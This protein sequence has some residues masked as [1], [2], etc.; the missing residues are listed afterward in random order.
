MRLDGRK[1]AISFRSAPS[2][3]QTLERLGY[4]Q[5]LRRSLG[6]FSSF[7]LSF[8]VI[9]MTSGLFADY[10]DGLRAGGPAFVWSWLIV[11]AGQ[12]LVAMVFAQLSRQIPLSGYAYQWAR[13]LAGDRL[14]FWAGWIMIVQF[15]TGM[16][17]VAYALASYLVPFFGLPNSNGNVVLA[18]VGTLVVAALINHYGIR[19][20]SMVNDVSVIAEILGSVLIGLA[21][22]GIALV[23][24]THPLSFLFTY[25]HQSSLGGY[26]QAFLA[27]SL[28]SVWTLGG[29]EAA[30]NVAEETHL[31]EKRIPIAILLSEVLAVVFGLL[32]L[33]GFTLAVPSVEVAS[34]DP[35]PLLYIIGS[36]FPKYVV[37][38]ALLCVSVA[39]FACVLA[40]LTT[41]TR[42]IWAMARDGKLPASRFLAKVSEH[43]V[44]VNAI[45]VVIPI[46]AVFTFW[47]QVEV[48]ILALCTF[49][50][51]VT[52]GLVVAACL[53]GKRP[54]SPS[55]AGQPPRRVS[56][57]LCAAALFWITGILVLL[58]YMTAMSLS[59]T[60]LVI[61]GE[62]AAVAGVGLLIYLVARWRA[63]RTSLDPVD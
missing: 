23:R 37:G 8:S 27:A 56:R 5:E 34:H 50:M 59:H 60:A 30:A 33:I 3:E 39:I 7:A 11:G 2:D 1:P 43:K 24:K 35:T 31:P 20:A 41:I 40:N 22:F 4:H 62:I 57:K 52:Y 51:Y 32:V 49:A 55:A 36:Y 16:A 6:Y 10:G 14:A 19:L 21:L 58:L 61:S 9:C 46:T 29:F 44:P 54:A 17:G 12:F 28:M 25:P 26:V 15:I 45:W 18:T 47:A 48:V 53:W 38:G 42:L 13:S 63:I